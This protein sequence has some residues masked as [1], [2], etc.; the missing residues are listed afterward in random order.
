MKPIS[1]HLDGTAC[2][3]VLTHGLHQPLALAALHG[4]RQTQTQ[5][6]LQQQLAGQGWLPH[7]KVA[8]HVQL[9]SGLREQEAARTQAPKP[10][11]R[12]FAQLK[13]VAVAQPARRARNVIDPVCPGRVAEVAAAVAAAVQIDLQD[14]KA[15]L[16]QRPRLQCNHA[17]RLVHL[18]AQWMDVDDETDGGPYAGGAVDRESLA[19][20]AR[21]GIHEEGLRLFSHLPA[22]QR[23]ADGGTLSRVKQ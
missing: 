9:C 10:Q 20:C 4:R 3:K 17:P 11:S 7:Q 19:A 12:P 5:E 1:G 2:C 8:L 6:L 16:R 18:L 14:G 13:G 23:R 15:G 21:L 22:T